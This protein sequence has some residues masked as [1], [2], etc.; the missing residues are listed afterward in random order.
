MIQ[1][2]YGREGSGG[3][4][5]TGNLK[6]P[7]MH[8]QRPAQA[9]IWPFERE[10]SLER[11]AFRRHTQEILERCPSEDY[12]WQRPNDEL[13]PFSQRD[14]TLPRLHGGLIAS[15]SKVVQ[16]AGFRNDKVGEFRKR[17]DILA[18]E[19]EGYAVALRTQCLNIRG[20]CDYA[21]SNKNWKW[22][23]YAAAVAAAFAKTV[24]L[25]LPTTKVPEHPQNYS[26]PG[27]SY[28][29]A[30]ITQSDAN[31]QGPMELGGS[32]S[33]AEA[34]QR[35]AN[36]F[37]DKSGDFAEYKERV[38]G[39]SSER[40]QALGHE[41]DSSREDQTE[42]SKTP[43]QARLYQRSD[44]VPVLPSLSQVGELSRRSTLP[45]S[46]RK[47]EQAFE[48]EVETSF[49]CRILE[50]KLGDSESNLIQ[51]ARSRCTL[52]RVQLPGFMFATKVLKITDGHDQQILLCK[53]LP[54]KNHPIE[55]KAYRSPRAPCRQYI[56]K[57]QWRMLHLY[58][59]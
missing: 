27:P 19:M 44:S 14:D 59:V 3:F 23:P 38:Y 42:S 46:F 18:F 12:T 17:G 57:L 5:E 36:W 8:L 26:I 35:D 4:E 20:I 28:D 47:A 50:A 39:D 43:L 7:D 1:F 49:D 58:M 40:S 13:D 55:I 45:S 54:I 29:D 22:Q 48:K 32:V 41:R 16:D 37:V 33:G 34:R 53:S 31:Q 15:S 2:E 24:I 51:L 30:H 21:D 56:D 11:K 9:I 25:G 6:A 52:Y 10:K